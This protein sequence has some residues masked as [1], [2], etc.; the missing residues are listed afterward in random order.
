M[1]PF[2]ICDVVYSDN[3]LQRTLMSSEHFFSDLQ[4]RSAPV[5]HLSLNRTT[6]F[7]SE[8]QTKSFCPAVAGLWLL[9]LFGP[10]VLL[11]YT[12]DI[13]QINDVAHHC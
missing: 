11:I 3:V 13:K 2:K 6:Q 10:T 1:D 5:G 12:T 4:W 8:Q 9:P 7:I